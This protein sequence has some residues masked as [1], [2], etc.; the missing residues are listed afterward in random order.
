MCL[1]IMA[2]KFKTLSILLILLLLNSICCE[3]FLKPVKV[4]PDTA[5]ISK[6][7]LNIV[8]EFLVKQHLPF[9]VVILQPIKYDA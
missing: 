8:D 7:L 1:R 3:R 2:R 4:H 6:V 5:V 9:D